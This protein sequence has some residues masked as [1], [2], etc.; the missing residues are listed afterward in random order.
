MPEDY[1][2][3]SVY[4]NFNL[5]KMGCIDK[6]SNFRYINSSELEEII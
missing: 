5:K 1:V 4:F 6:Y 2:V 3:E